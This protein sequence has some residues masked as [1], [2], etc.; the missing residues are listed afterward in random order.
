MLK[1]IL[2]YVEMFLLGLWKFSRDYVIPVIQFIEAVKELLKVAIEQDEKIDAPSFQIQKYFIGRLSKFIN[3]E[4]I[5]KIIV[6]FIEAVQEV[7]ISITIEKADK[8]KQANVFAA[9]IEYLKP[10]NKYQRSMIYLKIASR[11][12]IAI[13][14]AD[15]LKGHTAD[16]MVQMIYTNFKNKSKF[17]ITQ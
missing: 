11:I 9:F 15:K 6:A 7:C 5:K 14:P 16:V 10:L 12:L 17:R 4:L 13:V 1:Q 8:N 2:V 3:E